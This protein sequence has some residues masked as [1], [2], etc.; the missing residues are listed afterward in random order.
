M[1]NWCNTS[2]AFYTEKKNNSVLKKFNEELLALE[3]IPSVIKNDFGNW[4]LGN[5]WAKYMDSDPT[6]A[7]GG[8]GDITYVSSV[9][10]FDNDY[11]FFT[12]NTLTAWYFES[13]F[14]RKI[15][16]KNFPCI[17]FSFISEEPGCEVYYKHDDVG[18]FKD[19]YVVD[20]C[21]NG[22]YFTD[23]ATSIEGILD[24]LNEHGYKESL[25]FNLFKDGSYY[26][27]LTDT[28]DDEQYIS[29][30]QFEEDL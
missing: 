12:I 6:Y 5:V 28:E 7:K 2:I 1:P 8:R 22:D 11:D 10:S 14:W 15:I 30:H 19:E 4:W 20:G 23:Y 26:K 21:I 29:I 27:S 24:I 9:E 3:E 13:S 18:I 16:K 17:K 25:D